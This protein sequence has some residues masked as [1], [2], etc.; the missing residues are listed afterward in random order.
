M[1]DYQIF[2]NISEKLAKLGAIEYQYLYKVGKVRWRNEKQE[3]IAHAD[4]K[5][6]MSFASTDN[7]YRWG[8]YPNTPTLIK[9]EWTDTMVFNVTEEKTREVAIKAALEDNAEFMFAGNWLTLTLYL[10]CYNVVFKID[11]TSDDSVPWHPVEGDMSKY[12]DVINSI[13]KQIT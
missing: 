12:A 1:S 9:P 7:S 8:I 11:N 3:I 13:I 5:A 2:K 10:S 4:C 6:I